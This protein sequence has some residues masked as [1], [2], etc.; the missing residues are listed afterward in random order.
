MQSLTVEAAAHK[1]LIM[2]QNELL[3]RM[4]AR[5]VGDNNG[6]FLPAI[7]RPR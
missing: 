6:S 5:E 1:D 4:I 2:R 7:L 3:N